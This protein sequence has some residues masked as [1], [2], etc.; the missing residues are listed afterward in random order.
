MTIERR[1]VVQWGLLGLA[2]LFAKP[3]PVLGLTAD[4]DPRVANAGA[5]YPND[6]TKWTY[7]GW[8][9]DHPKSWSFMGGAVS[10]GQRSTIQ[11]AVSIQGRIYFPDELA[12]DRR[13]KIKW[14]LKDGYVPAPVSEWDAGPVHVKIYHFADRVLGDQATAVYSRVE[15]SSSSTTAIA[16]V[17][18]VGAASDFAIPLSGH[19]QGMAGD[20]MFYECSVGGGK[21][22]VRDFVSLANGEATPALLAGAGDLDS[23]YESMKT[24]WDGRQATLTHP[25]TL[26]SPLVVDMFKAL[27]ITARQNMIKVG[28]SNEI[29]A[30]PA[31]P[32][33][34]MSYDITFYHDIPNYI[35]QWMREGDCDFARKALDDPYYR[36]L[37]TT[38]YK[39]VN[40]ID[41]IGKYLLPAAEYLR[42]TG[43]KSY[44]TPERVVD[45]KKAAKNIHA[46]RVLEDPAHP[47]LMAK[48]Q[49]F[50]NWA[51]GGDYLLCDNW[52]ALHG[53]QA[54]KY[55][56]DYLG[57]NEEA[58]WAA[59]EMEDMNDCLNKAIEKC[60]L[61]NNTPYYFGAFDKE[62]L[63]RY[64]E[65]NYSWVP[66]SGALSTFPWGAYLKGF[67]L[68]GAWKDRFDVSIE[69]ALRERD[70]KRIPDGSWGSWWGQVTYGSAY[71]ASAGLQC[72]F[73]DKYRTEAI[74]NVEFMA[75]NQCAPFQWSEAYEFKGVDQWVGMYTPP[76][77]YGNYE[78]WGYSFAKQAL[79]QA[80]ASVKTDGTLILGRGVPN[81]WM[82]QGSVIEWVNI[83][84]NK[85]KKISFRIRTEQQSLDLELWGDVPDGEIL[86]NL[87]ILQNNIRSTSMGRIDLHKGSIA[88][89]KDTRK[90]RVLLT[91]ALPLG[92]APNL[93]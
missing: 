54:Y 78:C 19:P 50:E 3:S 46:T 24:H 69:Y 6:H 91:S 28:D 93:D 34:L 75:R 64:R 4:G 8:E 48:S 82:Y 33:G 31:N 44:F 13:Q 14:Y 92:S 37:N 88:L 70:K 66:Y 62:T 42:V 84:I 2:G 55:I 12:A 53:L 40:Y 20:R 52:G 41:T 21:I 58:K 83:T 51:E 80:C 30:A 56:C 57:D 7:F 15:L 65:S 61:E 22:E 35:D 45:M 49:D 38:N 60:C 17:L 72:L 16:V 5:F 11:F 63:D 86:L 10:P 67:E 1:T 27:Q 74:K 71:N 77:D 29:H 43:D 81:H 36:T 73:S 25:V 76:V 87:P 32:V 26:P 9:F 85:N 39:Y 23:H 47:G 18:N 59:A 79:L 68:G 90:V 89:P